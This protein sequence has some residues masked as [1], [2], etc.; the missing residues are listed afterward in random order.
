MR[1]TPLPEVR[2]GMRVAPLLQ[3]GTVMRETPLPLPAAGS[4]SGV[5]N[6]ES[7]VLVQ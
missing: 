4:H 3:E 6:T 7:Q 5:R 1:A 2:R